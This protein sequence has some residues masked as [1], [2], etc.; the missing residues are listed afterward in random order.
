M[1]TKIIHCLDDQHKNDLLSLYQGEWWS[2][3]RTPEDVEIILANSSFYIG[4]VTE[5]LMPQSPCKHGMQMRNKRAGLIQ[6]I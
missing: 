1:K 3:D 5:A 2:K 4:I 6:M